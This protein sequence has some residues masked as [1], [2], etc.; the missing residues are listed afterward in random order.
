MGVSPQAQ[1][2]GQVVA[3]EGKKE[4]LGVEAAN[5]GKV[6]KRWGGKRGWPGNKVFSEKGKKKQDET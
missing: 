5:L 1:E 4:Q 6:F 3:R 2:F